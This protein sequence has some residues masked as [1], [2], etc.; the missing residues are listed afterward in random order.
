M[1]KL[2]REKRIKHMA[3]NHLIR[4]IDIKIASEKEEKYLFTS[5]RKTDLVFILA[6]TAVRAVG[7]TCHAYFASAENVLGALPLSLNSFIMAKAEEYQ[8]LKNYEIDETEDV[9]L[10]LNIK[11]CKLFIK[12]INSFIDRNSNSLVEQLMFD[13]NRDCEF[14]IVTYS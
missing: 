12:E 8:L 9:Y 3:V 2:S 6:A 14:T 10:T 13:N 1:Q 11:E 4:N 5:K 7:D